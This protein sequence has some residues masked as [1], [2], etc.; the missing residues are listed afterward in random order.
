MVLLEV[1]IGGL[2]DTTNVVT[3]RNRSDHFGWPRSPG[4]TGRGRLR[5]SPSKRQES[6]R[7]ARKL[8]WVPLS[9]DAIAVCQE[10]AEQLAV[11][12]HAF[13]KDFGLEQDRFWNERVE[14]V[15]P[16]LGL[17]G[18]Y[19]RENA[20]VA[21]EAFF[22]YMEGLDQEVDIDQVKHA[23]QETR[24]PGR[25]ELFGTRCIWMAPIIHMLCCA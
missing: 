25:L 19:Q 9:D 6:L 12:L 24:W 21:M 14:L 8:W 16:S 11:A 2:L 13:Q 7:R 17:K 23:L 10:K 5:K 18:D 15:L 4:N 3:G 20:A 1:G 22:L